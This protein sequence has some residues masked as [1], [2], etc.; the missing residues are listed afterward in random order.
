MI[1]FTDGSTEPGKKISGAGVCFTVDQKL[2]WQGAFRV[3]TDSNNYLA[4]YA[5]AALAVALAPKDSPLELYE[6][7]K[8]AIASQSELNPKERH[9][10]RS[11]LVR[12]KLLLRLIEP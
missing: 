8:G 6:D 3:Y 5:A 7:N 2:V 1:A 10:I 9:R 11:P 12:G 4:E